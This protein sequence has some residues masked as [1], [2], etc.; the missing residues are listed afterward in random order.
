MIQFFD[1]WLLLAIYVS[2]GSFLV[3]AHGLFGSGPVFTGL[4]LVATT[5]GVLLAGQWSDYR[6][7]VC[8]ALFAAFV[9]CVA[10][11]FLKNGIGNLKEFALL[12]IALAAYPAGRIFA[13]RRVAPSFIVVTTLVVIAGTVVTGIALSEQ[14]N[15]PRGKPY[16][17]GEF[18]AAPAQ[19]T[20]SLSI[21]VIGMLCMRTNWRRA[22]AAMAVLLLVASAIFAASVVRFAF[23][24]LAIALAVAAMVSR[25]RERRLAVLAIAVMVAGVALG[26]VARSGTTSIFARYA[27]A[28]ASDTVSFSI[29]TP[30]VA[31]PT[32]LA[33][34]TSES[35]GSVAVQLALPQPIAA[36]QVSGPSAPAV[37][38]TVDLNNSIAIRRHLYSEAIGLLP[39]AGLFGIGLS[40]FMERSCFP[41]AEIHNSLL[42]AFVEVGWIGGTALMLLALLA[43]TSLVPLAGADGEARFALCGLVFALLMAMAHGSISHDVLLFAFLGY[44]ANVSSRVKLWPEVFASKIEGTRVSAL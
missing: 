28:V 25:P 41:D 14:W 9:A 22:G 37:C 5:L 17:F 10:V 27:V 18:A 29:A 24:A 21:L 13:G 3:F 43:I 38:Q 6:P 40:R 11:S 19:F 4:F 34:A 30:S 1:R 7:N 39:K 32:Q 26:N 23:V 36:G 33:A 35:T 20:I 42:Q 44:A 31:N 16:V 12:Q 15:D 8:D 2:T